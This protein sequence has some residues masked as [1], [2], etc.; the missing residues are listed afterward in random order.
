MSSRVQEWRFRAAGVLGAGLVGGLSLTTWVSRVGREHYLAFRREGRP[1]IFV[2]W[3]GQLVPLVHCHRD[4]RIVVLVSDH[5]DGEYITRVIE[6]RGFGTARGSSTRGSTK[7]LRALIRAARAG[8]DLALTPDGPRG[9]ARV[10]KPGALLVARATGL[11][12]IPVAVS[13]PTAWRLATWDSFMVPKP[14]A[15][16][17]IRYDRPHWIPS[18]STEE[19]LGEHAAALG[20]RL[21]ELSGALTARRVGQDGPEEPR[22]AGHAARAG[23]EKTMP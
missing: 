17:E 9:P 8:R 15:R 20:R 19:Q 2:L 11:P 22:A 4:E 5:P 10:F 21:D 7:G 12:L 13:A 1:V 18:G 6:R 16:V 23:R 3:H 14:L